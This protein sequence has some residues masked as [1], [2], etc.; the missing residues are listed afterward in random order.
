MLNVKCDSTIPYFTDLYHTIP[1][2][3]SWTGLRSSREMQ[4]R[5]LQEGIVLDVYAYSFSG[6]GSW[7]GAASYVHGGEGWSCSVRQAAGSRQYGYA[8]V[9]VRAV[10]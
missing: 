5:Q 2:H 9:P 1:Y 6:R 4:Q 3:T 8:R 10:C 7:I